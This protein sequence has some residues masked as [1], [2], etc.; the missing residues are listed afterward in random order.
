MKKE[1]TCAVI[2]NNHS[3]YSVMEIVVS[4]LDFIVNK[5][6]TNFLFHSG[7]GFVRDVFAVVCDLKKVYPNS[8]VVMV[9]SG[10]DT[11]SYTKRLLNGIYDSVI[12]AGVEGWQSQCDVTSMLHDKM[13]SLS[14]E[15][16]Q[17]P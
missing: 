13:K 3:S 11:N 7:G 8:S 2:G 10:D 15:I 17:S 6:I 12:F 9:F 1:N 16:F 14:S 4:V 5:G